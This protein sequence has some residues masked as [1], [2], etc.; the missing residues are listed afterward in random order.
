MGRD[1]G[2]SDVADA[3]RARAYH[4]SQLALSLVGAGSLRR[5]PARARADAR[6]GP[7]GATRR[8]SDRPLVARARG[9]RAGARRRAPRAHPA[10]GVARRLLAAAPLR[11][12]AP[13][14]RA[15]GSGRG[16]GRGARR[17]LGLSAVEVVYALL[18]WTAWWWLS[19]AAIFLAGLRACSPWSP[20]CGSCRSSTAS[21]R[22]PTAGSGSACSRSRAARRGPGDRRVRGGPVA[23]EPHRER[24]GGRTRPH[25]ADPALRHPARRVHRRRDRGGARPRARPPAFTAT[26]RRGLLVQGALTLV[27]VLVADRACGLGRR[28]SAST[29]P[30][31]RPGCRSSVSWCSSAWS[32]CPSPTAGRARSSS[33]PTTSRCDLTGNARAFIG[34]MERLATLNLAERGAASDQGALPLFPP[35]D[36]RRSHTRECISPSSDLTLSGTH[37][38]MPDLTGNM[39]IIHGI[40]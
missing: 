16:E 20:R 24:R 9:R 32:R 31:I 6:R 2:P 28:A 23:Q 34:A 12:P 7:S 30:R 38:D 40:I 21:R 5:V 19:G 33:R 25:P 35:V 13:V 37:R 10:A 4:R 17:R 3:R 11:A 36:R 15:A 26:S 39:R 27:H 14:T 22:S 1:V 8:R 18:R 29:D